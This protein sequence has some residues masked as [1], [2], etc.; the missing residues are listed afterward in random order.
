M[1]AVQLE[2]DMVTGGTIGN[3]PKD[4]VGQ[5]SSSPS[6][7]KGRSKAG[8]AL[9]RS[10]TVSV[11]SKSGQS[12]M[13][14]GMSRRTGALRSLWNHNDYTVCKIISMLAKSRMQIFTYNI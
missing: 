3:I 13:T 1:F 7:T 12:R 14:E 4:L 11:K 6:K 9:A 8:E 2:S 10:M 5:A